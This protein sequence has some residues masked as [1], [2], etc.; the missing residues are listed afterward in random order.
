MA[1][2]ARM[3]KKDLIEYGKSIGV[4]M[5]KSATKKDLL[6]AIKAKQNKPKSKPAKIVGKPVTPKK[7]KPNKIVG[8]PVDVPQTPK[9]SFVA[10]TKNEEKSIWQSIKEFFGV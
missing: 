7:A 4:T 1:N 6:T 5:G 2:P 9:K 10:E 3:S 8:K